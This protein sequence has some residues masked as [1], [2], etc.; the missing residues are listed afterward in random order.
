MPFLQAWM[1]AIGI[2]IDVV[3]MVTIE[4]IVTQNNMLKGIFS[5]TNCLDPTHVAILNGLA[6]AKRM[7]VICPT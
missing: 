6:V 1:T 3:V 7:A 5:D 2:V 4:A